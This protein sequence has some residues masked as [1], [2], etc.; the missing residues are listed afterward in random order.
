MA[1][2]FVQR[3]TEITD[4]LIELLINIIKR[5]STR[6][7]R[8]IDQELVADFKLVTGK[9]NILFRIAEVAVASPEGII[10]KVIYPVV[11]QKTLKDLVAEY[12]A[13]GIA[14]RLHSPHSNACI[15]CQGS[16]A[17]MSHR[18]NLVHAKV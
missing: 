10:E 13:T 3:S 9:T 15:I 18:P 6:A 17:K 12:K 8:R 11:S 5:I 4:N 7:Q 14:Y 2:F 16:D 1:A